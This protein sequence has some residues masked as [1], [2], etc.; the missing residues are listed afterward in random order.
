MIPQ[1]IRNYLDEH[2][3]RYSIIEHSPAYTAQE[4]AASTH[5]PGRE[6][7]KTVV[8]KDGDQLAIAV[9]PAPAKVSL[10]KMSEAAGMK[11]P[12][13]AAEWEFRPVFPGC[14]L[15]AMPPFGELY[16]VEV[17]VDE[18]LREDKEIA[19]NAGTH[20][21]VVVLPFTEFENLVH[22]KV[23]DISR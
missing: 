3:A 18:K 17:Y 10:V 22:P 9:V 19:F 1:A 11:N 21:D 14:E 16:G 23:V 12:Q 15:G 4:V 2:H 7:A 20:T 5:L 8:V 13:L 6:L